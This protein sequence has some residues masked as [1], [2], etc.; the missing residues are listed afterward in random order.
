[1][2]LV[3]NIPLDTNVIADM[4]SDQDDLYLVWPQARYPFDHA[5]QVQLYRR[6]KAEG[7]AG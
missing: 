4:I 2:N 6:I 5:Q 1:M 7:H 3:A